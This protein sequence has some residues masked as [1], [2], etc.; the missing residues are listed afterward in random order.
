MA[1]KTPAQEAVSEIQ[2]KA[3][4]RQFAQNYA[5]SLDAYMNMYGEALKAQE[6]F[7]DEKSPMLTGD[8]KFRVYRGENLVKSA[9]QP[10]NTLESAGNWYGFT[11]QK[12]RNYPM[13]PPDMFLGGAVTRSMEVTPLEIIDAA[14]AAQYDH[15][16]TVLDLNL[17]N[18]VPRNIAEEEYYR[19]LNKTDDNFSGL[20]RLL[21]EGRLPADAFQDMLGLVIDEG[22]FS[23]D[24]RGK[25]DIKETFKRGNVGIASALAARDASK[26]ALPYLL[27]GAGIAALP[28]DLIAGANRTG[29]DPQEEVAQAYGIDPGVFY[30]MEPEKFQKIKDAYDMEVARQM[31]AARDRRKG[32]NR[33]R[34]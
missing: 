33:P 31:Q 6:Y 27:K 21:L 5:R 2:Q 14:K 12:A 8:E 26:V 9:G 28:L 18:G 30:A 24:K 22:V 17:E 1:K 16:K 11:P 32:R 13:N 34:R 19:F 29:L 25:I 3:A 10:L 20:R 7:F 15:A 23:P 4:K